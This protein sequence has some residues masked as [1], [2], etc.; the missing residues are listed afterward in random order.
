MESTR[1]DPIRPAKTAA[2]IFTATLRLRI[3]YILSSI[4]RANDDGPLNLF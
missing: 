3:W 4:L 2:P 1:W